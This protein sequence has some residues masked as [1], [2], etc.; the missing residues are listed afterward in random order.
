MYSDAAACS[1]KAPNADQTQSIPIPHT[2][3]ITNHLFLP[4]HKQIFD[5]ITHLLHNYSNSAS[6]FHHNWTPLSKKDLAVT[7]LFLK[8]A[9]QWVSKLF[10]I[11]SMF[12]D[13]AMDSKT[14]SNSQLLAI[15]Q[16][17]IF[18]HLFQIPPLKWTRRPMKL[19]PPL[20]IL[21]PL[22]L[23]SRYPKMF[24]LQLP[25]KFLLNF[26]FHHLNSKII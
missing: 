14:M 6:S 8:C 19:S 21:K 2:L 10:L 9:K 25:W 26:W 24:Q 22:C 18:W 12:Y 15:G 3:T 4:F 20:Q 7:L 23:M 16:C 11:T 17:V 5:I 13:S 1:A